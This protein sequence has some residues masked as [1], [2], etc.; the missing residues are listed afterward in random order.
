[1]RRL[2]KRTPPS[3]AWAAI[4]SEKASISAPHKSQCNPSLGARHS[5]CAEAGAPDISSFTEDSSEL[6]F[7]AYPCQQDYFMRIS[8]KDSALQ[9]IFRLSGRCQE[10]NLPLKRPF[11][12]NRR[13]QPRKTA[14]I[15]GGDVPEWRGELR[16]RPD[17][18]TGPKHRFHLLIHRSAQRPQ[19][20]LPNSLRACF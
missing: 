2:A 14:P 7:K 13:K 5:P 17:S 15:A 9:T 4:P 8:R 1:M 20:A 3:E 16:E 12:R 6:A 10:A 19:S 18:A 11:G